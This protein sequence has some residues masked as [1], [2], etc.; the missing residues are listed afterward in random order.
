MTDSEL[1]SLLDADPERGLAALISQYGGYV[2]TVVRSKLRD[3]A[4]HEDIEE[5]V[6]DVFIAFWQ[7][8]REHPGE[9]I[10]L[11][12]MLAVIAKRK[13][14]TRFYALTKQPPPDDLDSLTVSDPSRPDESVILMQSVNDLGQPDSEIVLRKY[15]FGQSGKEIAAAL[16][17][18]PDAVDQRLSRARKRLRKIWKGE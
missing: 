2:L 5:T 18:T 12:A 15:Y 13:A 6:S 7:Y 8:R 16:G 1:L 4:S 3:A 9:E 10:C 11:R 14:I 17:M